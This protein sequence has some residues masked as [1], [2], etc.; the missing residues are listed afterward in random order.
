MVDLALLQSLSYM[1]GAI[2]VCVAAVYYVLNLRETTRNRRLTWANNAVQNMMGNPDFQKM[3][4]EVAGTSWSDFDDFKR[5]YDSSVNP[6]SYI[7][8]MC[9]WTN[10]ESYGRQLRQGLISIDSFADM[11]AVAIV[12]TWKRFKPVVEGYRG[13]QWPR[14][15]FYDW[16]YLAGVLEKKMTN[17]DPDFMKKLGN[18]VSPPEAHQ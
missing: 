16:E 18:I 7:A 5:K 9:V 10:F 8:R 4:M 14:S 15:A 2:G 12:R 3:Y 17:E 13:F 1:A 11:W 6:Q